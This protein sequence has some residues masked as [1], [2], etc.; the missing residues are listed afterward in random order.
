[1]SELDS[2]NEVEKADSGVTTEALDAQVEAFRAQDAVYKAADQEKKNEY[3][4]LED[5][6][7]KLMELL[8]KAGKKNTTW[9]ILAQCILLISILLLLLKL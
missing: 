6:K 7:R 8:D 2:W 3:K 4:K 5:E 9:K 1:M